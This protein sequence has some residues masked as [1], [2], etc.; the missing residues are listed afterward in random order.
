MFIDRDVKFKNMFEITALSSWRAEF[1]PVLLMT[2][3]PVPSVD[4]PI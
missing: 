2:I 3:S 1:P 4:A